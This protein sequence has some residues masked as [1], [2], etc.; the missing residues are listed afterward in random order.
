MGTIIDPC[1]WQFDN[2]QPSIFEGEAIGPDYVYEEGYNFKPALRNIPSRSADLDPATFV[3]F[4]WSPKVDIFLREKIFQDNRDV[5][6][7]SIP[8]LT[9]L[10]R[11]HYT[12]L[13]PH[14]H[15]IYQ[16]I[17]HQGY[18]HLIPSIFRKYYL[19]SLGTD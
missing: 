6:T 10:A 3:H 8:E 17:I 19:H 12:Q 2:S 7:L 1:H 4:D 16:A 13:F 14:L 5:R 18:G 15:P 9:F 11:L